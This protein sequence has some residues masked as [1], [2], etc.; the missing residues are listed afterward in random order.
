M[1]SVCKWSSKQNK[2][3]PVNFFLEPCVKNRLQL[4]KLYFCLGHNYPHSNSFGIYK[5][6]SNGVLIK[7]V[8]WKYAAN[9]QENTQVIVGFQDEIV[10]PSRF[11]LYYVFKGRGGRREK[12]YLHYL[13]S[14]I[15]ANRRNCRMLWADKEIFSFTWWIWLSRDL[16]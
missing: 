8:F 11:L 13:L 16:L 4:Y 9:L 12:D 10:K 2:T 15:S 3:W 5:Q 7:K 14:F 1:L 6:P